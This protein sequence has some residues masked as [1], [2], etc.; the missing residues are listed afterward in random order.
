M[1]LKF[2]AISLGLGIQRTVEE[3]AS[4][5]AS[6]RSAAARRIGGTPAAA[7]KDDRRAFQKVERLIKNYENVDALVALT[8]IDSGRR[9][10]ARKRALL[11]TRRRAVV[12]SP[13]ECGR[14]FRVES[15]SR[16]PAFVDS[17]AGFFSPPEQRP[18]PGLAPQPAAQSWYPKPS[19]CHGTER[20]RLSEMVLRFDDAAQQHHEDHKRRHH[21]AEI[22][23]HN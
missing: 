3:F 13:F 12:A 11:N 10:L 2:C 15:N 6:R 9:I 17:S 18:L 19:H 20:M 21:R 7:T 5:R 1:P 4:P 8:M 23:N 14:T 16:P 22:C